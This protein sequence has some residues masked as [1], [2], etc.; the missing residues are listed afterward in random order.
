MDKK[1]KKEFKKQLKTKGK[2][3]KKR[4]LKFVIF[5]SK[6][7]KIPHL[8]LF[9]YSFVL[10][11][12]WKQR[13]G[14]CGHVSHSRRMKV[15]FYFREVIPISLNFSEEAS[16]QNNYVAY[17]HVYGANCTVQKMLWKGQFSCSYT[18]TMYWLC[19]L[20]TWVLV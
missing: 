2:K 7:K 11:L 16:H 18:Q 17:R 20:L 8:C 1:G 19:S 13:Y 12:S 14:Q 5:Q 3:F 10:P 4:F 9:R 6:K 15:A